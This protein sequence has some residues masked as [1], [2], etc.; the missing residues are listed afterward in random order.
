MVI[1]SSKTLIL[2]VYFIVCS[3]TGLLFV[4]LIRSEQPMSERVTIVT[5]F[6]FL[7]NLVYALFFEKKSIVVSSDRHMIG[8]RE[9]KLDWRRRSRFVSRETV[10]LPRSANR[11]IYDRLVGRYV[12]YD[13]KGFGFSF[14]KYFFKQQNLNKIKNEILIVLGVEW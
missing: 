3:L 10:D 14:N 7:F 11:R 13:K 9:S 4:F 6:A 2:L 1:K 12:V 5:T 8:T